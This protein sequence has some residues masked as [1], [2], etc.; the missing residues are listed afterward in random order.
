V[1]QV[2]L[3]AR[4]VR[5]RLV[6]QVGLVARVVRVRLVEQVG[7]VARVVRVRL[8]EQVGLVARAVRARLVEQ[9]GPAVPVDPVGLVAMAGLAC[10]IRCRRWIRSFRLDSTQTRALWLSR[11]RA[12]CGWLWRVWPSHWALLH[13]CAGARRTTD[14]KGRY[15]FTGFTGSR[16]VTH[17]R[18]LA[19]S[20]RAAPGA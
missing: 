20:M 2:G 9:V 17:E 19:R 11:N 4:A 7:P 13:S 14:S 8:V 10:P 12:R 16:R 3:V 5:A 15:R 6:E 18:G 1:E